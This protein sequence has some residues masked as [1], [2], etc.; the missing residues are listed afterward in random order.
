[1]RTTNHFFIKTCSSLH[2]N[3]IYSDHV[4]SSVINARL[5]DL[6]KMKVK[7]V[8]QVKEKE[9]DPYKIDLKEAPQ[10]VHEFIEVNWAFLGQRVYQN[11]KINSFQK[12]LNKIPSIEYVRQV[13]A[14]QFKKKRY[15]KHLC[16]IFLIIIKSVLTRRK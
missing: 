14:V 11:L 3:M 13:R 1:M 12:D 8:K 6:R 9:L 2:L 4:A 7:E 5:N 16:K 15:F 10:E